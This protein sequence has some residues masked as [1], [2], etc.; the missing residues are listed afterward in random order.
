MGADRLAGHDAELAERDQNAPFRNAQAI[1][2]DIN[3]RERLRDE[4]GEHIEAIREEFL[5]LE[6]RR[7]PA[8]LRRRLF[9]V[10][11]GLVHRR[12]PASRDRSEPFRPVVRGKM[13]ELAPLRNRWP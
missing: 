4:A 12:P 13:T 3:A 11:R 2:I 8:R 5:E 1:T 7:I 10:G 6:G 9:P